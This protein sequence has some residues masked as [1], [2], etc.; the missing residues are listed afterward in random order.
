MC[1]RIHASVIACR[2]Y[3]VAFSILTGSISPLMRGLHEMG[4]YSSVA[5]TSVSFCRPLCVLHVKTMLLICLC[6]W[7]YL[8]V[9][10]QSMASRSVSTWPVLKHGP[11]SLT[12][13]RVTRSWIGQRGAMKVK[14][15]ELRSLVSPQGRWG[16]VTARQFRLLTIWR[17]CSVHVGTRKMVN[18]AWARRS[19]RKLWWRSVAILT[20]KSIV[21][22]G[23]RGERLIEPSSSWF[24][25][26]FPSG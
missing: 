2:L 12:C 4:A 20:C 18:Y 17:S 16:A 1:P 6:W 26:K 15:I 24:P 19:Q 3:Y 5:E 7:W 10:E 22:P 23:Y 9:L 21:R 13:A 11:R 25:L 8:C 14:L